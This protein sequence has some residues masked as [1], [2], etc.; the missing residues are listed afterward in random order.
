MMLRYYRSK[1]LAFVL[2]GPPHLSHSLYN[3]F[4]CNETLGKPALLTYYI[5]AATTT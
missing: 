3:R 5:T 4:A 2:L 1:T